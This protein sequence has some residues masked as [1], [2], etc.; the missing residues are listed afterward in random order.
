[1]YFSWSEKVALHSFVLADGKNVLL[2]NWTLVFC[3]KNYNE[4]ICDWEAIRH[5]YLV[6]WVSARKKFK[7]Y[8]ILIVLIVIILNI[9]EILLFTSWFFFT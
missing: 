9:Y 3:S 7:K 2:E 1:M 5:L 6:T 8:I 4:F